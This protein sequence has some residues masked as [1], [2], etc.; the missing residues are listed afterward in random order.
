MNMDRQRV[1]ITSTRYHK[2]YHTRYHLFSLSLI[3]K[4]HNGTH[5][6]NFNVLSHALPYIFSQLTM[7]WGLF[8]AGYHALPS[9]L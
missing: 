8:A 6:H 4:G 1:T 9:N 2:R 5:Y 3:W 7:V